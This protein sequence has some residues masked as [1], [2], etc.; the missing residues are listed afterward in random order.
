MVTTPL[1]PASFSLARAL[2]A[3]SAA[4]FGITVYA[5]KPCPPNALIERAIASSPA[6]RLLSSRDT[7][8]V[9]SVLPTGLIAGT[10]GALHV[11]VKVVVAAQPATAIRM[12]SVSVRGR[13]GMD[14]PSSV[15]QATLTVRQPPCGWLQRRLR[16]RHDPTRHALVLHSGDALL[17]HR[18]RLHA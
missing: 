11:D 1:A 6:R 16:S 8:T 12:V 17:P 4:S 2:S 14:L 5:G 13:I 3:F 10:S 9:A 18:G 7:K 15:R